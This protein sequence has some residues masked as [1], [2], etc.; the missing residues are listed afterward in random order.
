MK[1]AR[2]SRCPPPTYLDISYADLPQKFPTTT[3]TNVAK[4]SDHTIR[5]WNKTAGFA[6]RPGGG[7]IL[8]DRDKF[9]AFLEGRPFEP[10]PQDVTPHTK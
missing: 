8:V 2:K 7:K 3:A 9:I 1:N 6:N 4:V 10:Y 5:K